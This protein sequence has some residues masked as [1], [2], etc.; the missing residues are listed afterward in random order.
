MGYKS[1]LYLKCTNDVLEELLVTINSVNLFDYIT[2]L[3]QD[4]TYSTFVMYD[5]K[6]YDSYNDVQVINKKLSELGR[7]SK[8]T[9]IREGEDSDDIQSYGA[10]PEELDLYY[11]TYIA[12]DNFGYGEDISKS[13]KQDLPE[14]FL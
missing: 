2:E 8:A 5:L 12:L 7:L 10:D 13:I 11:H 3:K 9:M 14:L 6:W 1:D 4:N